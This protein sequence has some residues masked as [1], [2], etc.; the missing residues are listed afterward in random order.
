[1]SPAPPPGPGVVL[2]P[3]RVG[4]IIDASSKIA[5]RNVRQLFPFIAPL[6]LP[7]LLVNSLAVQQFTDEVKRAGLKG[8][9]TPDETRVAIDRLGELLR[10][11]VAYFIGLGVAV[12]LI[13]IVLQT[14]ASAALTVYIGESLMGRT[15]DKK[16]SLKLALRRA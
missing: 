8:G 16:A 9:L 5:T 13:Q 2:R 1:M 3:L 14:V 12:V 10:D 11:R 7:F 6:F 4:E 15:P